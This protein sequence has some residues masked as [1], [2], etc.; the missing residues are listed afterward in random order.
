MFVL[1]FLVVL[2]LKMFVNH[3]QEYSSIVC[4]MSYSFAIF[5][6]LRAW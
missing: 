4:P 3:H 6:V 5:V 1:S 2:V